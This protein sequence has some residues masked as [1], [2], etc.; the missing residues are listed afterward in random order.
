[1][2]SDQA[3][4]VL[5]LSLVLGLA[6][7]PTT[8]FGAEI[9]LEPQQII[10]S[11]DIGFVGSVIA[12]TSFWNENGNAILT[13]YSLIVE[14]VTFSESG[15]KATAGDTIRL[16]F[17]GGTL[18]DVTTFVSSSMRLHV[19]Q[20]Y[21]LFALYDG[22]TYANPIVG[23]A[24]GA[25]F[26][27]RDPI[28]GQEIVASFGR[29]AIVQLHGERIVLGSALG[30]DSAR[31]SASAVSAVPPPEN[32]DPPSN[33]PQDSFSRSGHGRNSSTVG[34]TLH[35]FLDEVIGL[36]KRS[37]PMDR[38]R[39]RQD[40]PG[41][42]IESKNGRLSERPL[43]LL[44]HEILTP[45]A[46]KM[47]KTAALQSGIRSSCTALE[48][49]GTNAC[50][51]GYLDVVANIELVPTGFW[52]YGTLSASVASWNN[53]MPIWTDISSNGTWGDND[54][55]EIAGWISEADLLRIYNFR[56]GSAIGLTMSNISNQCGR[57]NEADVFFNPRES[58]T[59]DLSTALA[60][61]SVYLLRTV[62]MHELGHVWGYFSGVCD[63]TYTYDF[64]SV[65][66][67]YNFVVEDGYG[68]HATDAYMIRRHYDDQAT[69]PKSFRDLGVE[70]YYAD[71]YLI[72]STTNKSTY[73]QGESITLS[74]V[75]VENMS[76]GTLSDVRV[77]FYLS[78]DRSIST[79]DYR[80]GSYWYWSTFIGEGTSVWDYTTEIP[81]DIPPGTYYVGAIVTHNGLNNDDYAA[82]N[83]TFFKSTI[84][85]EQANRAPSLTEITDKTF[86]E[87]DYLSFSVNAVDPD[88]DPITYSAG[89]L[90]PGAGFD[91]AN[92]TLFWQPTFAQA[93]VYNGVTVTASDGRLSDV[94]FFNITVYNVNRNP[95]LLSIPDVSANEG[96][97]VLIQLTGQDPD[98]DDRL[99]Y[100]SP[101]LPSGATLGSGNGLFTWTPGF[102]DAGNYS[103]RFKVNDGTAEDERSANINVANFNRPPVFSNQQVIDG[104]EGTLLTY[105][106]S[107]TDPDE[108]DNL[109]YSSPNVPIGSGLD[110]HSGAFSW[111]PSFDQAGFYQVTFRVTD[112]VYEDSDTIS[113]RIANKNRPPEYVVPSQPVSGHEGVALTLLLTV[114]D[115]DGDQVSV[116]LVNPPP[117]MTEMM[118]GSGQFECVWIPTYEQSGY[119]SL[120][121]TV[122]DTES[123]IAVKVD[124]YIANVNRPPQFVGLPDGRTYSG[125]EDDSLLLKLEAMDPDTS[126]SVTYGSRTLPEGASLN[127][128]TGILT[129]KPNFDQAGKYQLALFICDQSDTTLDLIYLEIENVNR[130]P[131]QFALISPPDGS[132]AESQEGPRFSWEISV[133]PDSGDSVK[134]R[135]V[136]RGVDGST[137]LLEPKI[138]EN[139]LTT[140]E[141]LPVGEYSW[142]V[143]AIDSYGDSTLCRQSFMLLI[144]DTMPPNLGITLHPNPVLSAE[145]DIFVQS[146]E[147]LVTPPTVGYRGPGIEASEKT[148]E[149]AQHNSHLYVA[150][151]RLSTPGT[152]SLEV[153]G[154]DPSGNTGCASVDLVGQRKEAGS[155]LTVRHPSGMISLNLPAA[156]LSKATWVVM[157]CQPPQLDESGMQV[158]SLGFE[159]YPAYTELSSPA[160]IQYIPAIPVQFQYALYKVSGVDT[161]LIPT[162][163]INGTL[164]GEVSSLGNF[165]VMQKRPGEHE[166]F[167]TV[168]PESFALEQNWPNPFNPST[169]I[170]FE[171]KFSSTA[172]LD[173]FNILGQRVATLIDRYLSAGRHTVT[174]AGTD[175]TG[176]TV[177][178][179]IYFYRLSVG[180]VSETKRMI[181]IK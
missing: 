163:N 168:L 159:L 10:S 9:A 153:C 180:E 83:T 178:S 14:A 48:S 24:Q 22:N 76:Y 34:M 70:S 116:N 18:N 41:R 181:L 95:F 53:Y 90:P 55:N 74:D 156:S 172:K 3:N 40:I 54:V 37:G 97:V 111:I 51:C 39:I 72:S 42:F 21:V 101:N 124:I 59:D 134:Y 25:F 67:A 36:R 49:A 107:A 175:Q 73:F 56:W 147:E 143:V 177:P 75:L 69:I 46:P 119:Y 61:P 28:Q 96:K 7:S 85:V 115:Q 158:R 148:I 165:V 169:Q 29:K 65:M 27:D 62:A 88:G 26:V 92:R 176:N 121:F 140:M 30:K 82:N 45:R 43:D 128:L 12:D 141:R 161:M 160:T 23:G 144:R 52:S 5:I 157:A 19:G 78:T 152:Y 17:A 108:G 89:N 112:G 120:E 139:G 137:V 2:K 151:L 150:D 170:Q 98:S 102:N 13:E 66:H 131:R 87:G 106:L 60:N 118:N 103:I 145:I 86:R 136:L 32:G 11:A 38:V 80:L 149:E 6:I 20:K 146:N 94:E 15:I 100:S 77:R 167:T 71:E 33:D 122:S 68:V 129:W 81:S 44:Y 142:Q 16:I 31:L 125:R 164:C 1:M 63:E 130:K 35:E 58:W 109:I 179:G 155:D 133:D 110:P 171:T 135:F 84:R 126:D 162:R 132:I 91:A 8:A 117:G 50:A 64:A 4:P 114:V 173:I 174:W 105:S 93:G 57:I 79:S 154:D 104:I 99:S 123:S 127:G 113:F 47:T 138:S 166:T